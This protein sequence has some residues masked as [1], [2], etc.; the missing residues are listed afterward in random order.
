VEGG[1][2]DLEVGLGFGGSRPVDRLHQREI[3]YEIACVAAHRLEATARGQEP[4]SDVHQPPPYNQSG[5]RGGHQH[6]GSLLGRL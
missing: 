1:G 3:V 6:W 5:W 4:S 2:T